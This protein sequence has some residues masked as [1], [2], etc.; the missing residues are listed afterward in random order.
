MDIHQG[1]RTDQAPAAWQFDTMEPSLLH[2]SVYRTAIAAG[3]GS[4][5]MDRQELL[6]LVTV[7]AEPWHTHQVRHRF[8]P[9]DPSSHCKRQRESIV[10]W[11]VLLEYPCR[12]CQVNNIA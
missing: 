12:Y 11:A 1:L 9:K 6:M 10:D 8:P 5:K 3:N 7:L 2:P 4:G